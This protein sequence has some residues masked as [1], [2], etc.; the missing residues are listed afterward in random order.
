M[1]RYQFELATCADDAELRTIIAQ[2]PMPGRISVSFRRE[3]SFFDATSVEGDFVQII[4]CRDRECNRIV[5]FGTRSIRQ[6]YLNGVA[7]SIGYLSSLRALP[8]H[9]GIGL[10]ARGYAHFR[11]LHND[12]RTLFYLTTIAAGNEQAIGV[13]TSGRANLPRYQPLGDFHTLA[14]PIRRRRRFSSVDGS[15]VIRLAKPKD[16][17]T[18]MQFVDREGSARQLYP[19]FNVSDLR[20]SGGLLRGLETTDILLAERRG[21]IVGTLAA[22]DQSPFRQSVAHR[23]GV[24]FQYTRLLY[25]AW[26][27]MRRMPK[28]PRP[29]KPFRYLTGTLCLIAGDDIG[30]FR[31]LLLHTLDQYAEQPAQHLLLGMHDSDPLLPIARRYASQEYVTHLYIVSFEGNNAIGIDANS[32]SIHLEL[33]TL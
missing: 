15:L 1:G 14:I 28:L 6:R 21:E 23:Y 4:V 10:L 22:W 13:L 18:I 17:P 32:R 30:V 2:T 5:G 25:N 29:G 19:Q 9:R 12:G 33:G 24:A 16:A 26:A 7:T 3:P 20:A 27:T 31:E 8:A 11:E